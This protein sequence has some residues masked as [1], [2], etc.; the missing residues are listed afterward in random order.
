MLLI[1]IRM[2]EPS[3]N[4]PP[5]ATPPEKPPPAVA[6]RPPSAVSLWAEIVIATRYLTRLSLPLRDKAKPGQIRRSMAWFPL[7]GAIVGLTGAS[8]DWIMSQIYLPGTITAVF[9]VIGMLWTTRAIHE[10]EFA[11][12]AN[13]Y[14]QSFDKEQKGGGWLREERSVRY[15]TLAVIFVIIMK[16]GA[17]AS[18]AS[19]T[20]VFQALIAACSW[21]RALMV[22]AACWLRP[23]EGDPVADHFQQPPALRMLV[24]LG[25][26]ALFT[27]VT[28]GPYT[29]LS[30]A[31]GAGTGL[32]VALIGAN[33]VRGYN[34]PLLGTLQQVVELSVLG[35]IL[36]VQ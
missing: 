33:Q 30:L 35:V 32:L 11:S 13:Q 27:F 5:R 8:I 6:L 15:G 12:L 31:T 26:G 10:E 24:A 19:T 4:M 36:A 18:L 23:I 21:S 25:L 22:V 9:A 1:T 28:L 17:I 16:I 2:T 20:L 3:D 34:G 29:A 7:I 14:S